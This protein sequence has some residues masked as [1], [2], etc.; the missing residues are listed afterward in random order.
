MP[1]ISVDKLP[2]GQIDDYS[3]Q[4]ILHAAKKLC[5]QIGDFRKLDLDEQLDTFLDST[6]TAVI[7]TLV[8]YGFSSDRED[9]IKFL[10]KAINDFVED[11]TAPPARVER[12]AH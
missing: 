9:A 5:G 6:P 12:D 10:R 2:P 8:S 3:L 4:D 11:A 7:D 1:T